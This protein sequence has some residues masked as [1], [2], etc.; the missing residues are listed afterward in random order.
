MANF[1]NYY[2]DSSWSHDQCKTSIGELRSIRDK[3][4]SVPN[5]VCVCLL[6]NSNILWYGNS[7]DFDLYSTVHVL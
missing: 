5:R 3:E 4:I 6:F 2:R 1:H 7:M